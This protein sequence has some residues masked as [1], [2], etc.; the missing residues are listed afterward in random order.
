M[1]TLT[2]KLIPGFC[3]C[4]KLAT[5]ESCEYKE[6]T[7]SL[8]CSNQYGGSESEDPYNDSG[9]EDPVHF[10]GSCMSPFDFLP[11]QRISFILPGPRTFTSLQDPDP[12]F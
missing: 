11:D 9:S 8:V 3:S 1:Q 10:F 5:P 2:E 7:R 4:K 12:I 6:K